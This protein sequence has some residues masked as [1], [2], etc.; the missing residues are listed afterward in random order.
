VSSERTSPPVNRSHWQRPTCLC[1]S[2]V[3][4]LSQTGCVT[5]PHPA[6]AAAAAPPTG[7]PLGRVRVISTG[8]I[9]AFTWQCP[10]PK[11]EAAWELGTSAAH[12]GLGEEN[13]RALLGVP[14]LNLASLAVAGP[15]SMVGAVIGEAK[16]VSDAKFSR[17]DAALRQAKPG[18]NIQE[19]LRQRVCEL[20]QEKTAHPVV[21]VKKPFPAGLE[22]DFSRMSCV[23]AGTLAWLPPGQTARDYLVSQG[24]DTVLEVQLLDPGLRGKE[25]INPSLQLCVE[26]RASLIRVSD[27]RVL[28]GWSMDYRSES[29]K[30]V[31]WARNDAEL[32]RN[33]LQKFYEAASLEIAGQLRQFPA[34]VVARAG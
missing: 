21:L 32:L 5:P 4:V 25:G 19:S 33:E 26:L 30:F 34:P 15:V 23:M 16:G 18:L 12:L 27:E 28:H 3:F 24:V 14:Y 6:L 7:E 2:I 31:E 17:S 29:R 1:F 13:F 8:T 22:E 20:L 10:L 11:S 9:P